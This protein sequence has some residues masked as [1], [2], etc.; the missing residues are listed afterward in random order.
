M[1]VFQALSLATSRL[2]AAHVPD[3]ALDADLLL[4]HVLGW[5]R[6]RLLTNGASDLDAAAE[7]RFLSLLAE[8]ERRR[9]LQHLTGTQAFWRHDFLVSP[10]ALIPRP[11][12]EIL[13]EACLEELR[14]RASPRILDVGTGSGC[15]AL[16][17]ALERPDAEVH[18]VDVSAGALDVAREN[19]RRLRLTKRVRFHLGDLLEPVD[20]SFDLVASNPPYVDAS[21]IEGLEPEV[22][23]HE[24]RRALV[25][26]SG[27]RYSVYGRLVPEAARALR[28]AGSLVVEVGSGMAA[29]VG[30]LCEAAGL[31]VQR[32]VPDLQGIPRTVVARKPSYPAAPL[33]T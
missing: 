27:D 30:R 1:T 21:E 6:A 15:I 16:S 14:G 10:K 7:G 11:E 32:V 20:G 33:P 28:P 19:A 17:L 5:D 9:P 22:R 18:A 2:A 24:P 3:P 26:L 8:R 12:T 31:P 23:V 13:L 25:P 4:R 29:E